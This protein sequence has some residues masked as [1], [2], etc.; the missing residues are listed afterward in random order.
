[1]R[2][3]TDAFFDNDSFFVSR[4]FLSNAKGSFGLMVT[5]S[6]DAARQLCVAARGQTISVAFYPKKGLI[7]YGSE[8][9]AVKAGLGAAMPGGDEKPSFKES[10]ERDD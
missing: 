5:N 4:T 9:A 3:A 1:M 2:S 7:C 6:L 8:Q 10:A